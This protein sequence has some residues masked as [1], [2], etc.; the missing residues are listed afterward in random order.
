MSECVL[1]RIRPHIP[2]YVRYNLRM[3]RFLLSAKFNSRQFREKLEKNHIVVDG[4][5]KVERDETENYFFDFIETGIFRP[6]NIIENVLCDF[7]PVTKW[8]YNYY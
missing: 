3:L 2:S 5:N 6:K 1:E 7:L 8:F 4:E